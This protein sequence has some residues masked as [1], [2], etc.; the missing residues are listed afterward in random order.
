MEVETSYTKD[1]NHIR[2]NLDLTWNQID[3][4]YLIRDE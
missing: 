1:Y 4:A 3:F 2:F